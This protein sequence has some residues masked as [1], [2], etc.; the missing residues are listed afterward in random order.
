ML[1]LIVWGAIDSPRLAILFAAVGDGFAAL[2]TILKAWKY[3]E[4]ETGLTY[5]ASFISVLLIIPSISVWNIENSAFQIYLLIA[6]TFLVFAAY[7]KRLGFKRI[8]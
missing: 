7:R 2:P 8:S 5:I 4:T 3:P 1:A 6:D